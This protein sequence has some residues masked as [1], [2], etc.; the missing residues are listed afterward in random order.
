MRPRIITGK[1]KGKKLAVPNGARPVTDRIKT[2]IFDTLGARI[3]GATFLDLY[4]GS[5]SMGFEAL[6]RGASSATFVDLGRDTK[7]LIFE[8]AKELGVDEEKI[9]VYRTDSVNF[10][11]KFK[12]KHDIIFCDPP[13]PDARDF[14]YHLLK[15]VMKEESLSILRVPAIN[16]PL[17]S[18]ETMPIVVKEKF[19]ASRIY[20]FMLKS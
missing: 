12:Y 6:S 2:S 19:S 14:P 17:K 13:F 4:C 8:N 10:L 5:G 7:E 3:E 11:K 18:L 16:P 15:K 1:F 9:A 20:Y